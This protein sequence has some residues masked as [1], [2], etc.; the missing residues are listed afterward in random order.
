MINQI[1]DSIY[2]IG[3]DDNDLDLFEH[4]YNVQP[5]GISY[6]S[7]VIMDEKITIMDTIDAR[8]SNEWFENISNVLSGKDPYYLVVSHMEPDHAANIKAVCDKYPELKVIG[9]AKTFTFIDQFFGKDFL[10]DNRREIVTDGSSISI[11][12][13]DL[14][15]IFAPMVHWPEVMVT[16]DSTDKVL[17]SADAFGRFGAL[18]KTEKSPWMPLARVYYW[19][20]VGKY[21]TQV[22]QLLQ[23]AK[24]LDI[25]IICPLHGPVLEENLEKY[26]KSYELW[27]SRVPEDP[28]RVF[29]A[30]GSI[31]G[32]T[33]KAAKLLS[34]KLS[35]SGIPNTV[36]DLATAD[37]T[38]TIMSAF[39]CGKIVLAAATYD[40]G[41]FPAMDDFLHHLK[42]KD[43]QNRKV[44]IIENGSWG[45]VAGRLMI[46]QL[47]KMKNI[48][49]YD[50]KVTIKSSLDEN[51]IAQLEQLAKEIIDS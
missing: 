3:V 36:C 47:E 2:Y 42:S 40:G 14:T 13:H 27:A 12:K 28:K 18:N 21:C 45:P 26:I 22:T 16:Y 7:Y 49:I 48:D 32:N 41:I 34:E 29:I 24:T 50:T 31:Y 39:Y 46:E 1:T 9:N 51:S 33:A 8:C 44:G 6:N 10:S 15:F 19:N 37:L 38:F 25:N 20:I 17:F 43:F 30:H 5:Y 4:Q 35:A 11:G 23:K